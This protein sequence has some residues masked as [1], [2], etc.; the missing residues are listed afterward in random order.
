MTRK[1]TAQ[2]AGGKT[3]KGGRPKSARPVLDAKASKEARDEGIG[4]AEANAGQDWNDAMDMVVIEVAQRKPW[5]TSDDV[6]E[7]AD[8]KGIETPKEPRALGGVLRRAAI[9]RVCEKEPV[10]GVPTRRVSRHRAPLTVWRSLHLK[11]P[12]AE[13]DFRRYG[14]IAQTVATPLAEF[15]KPRR[16]RDGLGRVRRPLTASSETRA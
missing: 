5:F 12:L 10:P 1:T 8:Q 13:E 7:L 11:K 2:R 16:R 4:R 6:V 9:D 15:P 14:T 3:T